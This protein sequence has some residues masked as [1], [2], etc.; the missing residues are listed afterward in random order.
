MK[1]RLASWTWAHLAVD[2]SCFYIL[3]KGVETVYRADGADLA[4]IGI[5]IM[6]YNCIAFG[7]QMVFGSIADQHPKVEKLIGTVGLT[8][9]TIPLVIIWVS[10]GVIASW[11]SLVLCALLN[12]AFHVGGGVDVLKNSNG[13]IAPSGIFVSSG[14]L[15]VILGTLYGKTDHG[16]LLPM[17]IVIM[18]SIL[19]FLSTEKQ[20]DNS[21]M[22]NKPYKMLT[23]YGVGFTSVCL[24]IAVFIRSYAGIIWPIDFEKTGLL[25]LLPAVSSC[26]GK[27][28]G[29]II[30]DKVGA[31]ETATVS[32]ALSMALLFLSGDSWIVTGISI[33]LFN[34]AMPITLCGLASAMPNHLGFAFGLSTF[35]LLL[36]YMA[37]I[38][39]T[40]N[41]NS[42]INSKYIITILGI[43]AILLIALSLRS[44]TN[45]YVEKNS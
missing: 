40:F 4:T 25:V 10:Q 8:F 3:Y 20:S 11:V 37:Y 34:I 35:A 36:G 32:L 5:A 39:I 22:P 26:L 31:M 16:A 30:A 17:A 7:L 27:A 44:K 41:E 42:L 18:A 38:H 29:G 6:L 28:L 12:A 21:S 43:V 14:A 9:M 33:L 23:K 45:R 24:F 1:T 2:M 15:G 13:R 19:L